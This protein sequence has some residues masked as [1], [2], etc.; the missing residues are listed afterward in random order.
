MAKQQE[1]QSN[2]FEGAEAAEVAIKL[3]AEELAQARKLASEQG[4]DDEA[5]GMH[6][7][8]SNGLSYLQGLVRMEQIAK[9]NGDAPA[10]IERLTQE[11]MDYQSKYAVM[12]FRAFLLQDARDALEMHVTGLKTEN[13][14]SA[15]RLWQFRADEERL[16][17]EL[18]AAQAEVAAL[19]Q[20]LAV[21]TGDAPPPPPP[22][23]LWARI[24]GFLGRRPA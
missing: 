11:L 17:I 10:E 7:I 23:G 15:S 3:L 22:K 21:L 8:F 24:R 20:R 18:V 6:I 13:K 12:K 19:T 1:N 14:W 2:L 16:K 5:E 9:S 4:W